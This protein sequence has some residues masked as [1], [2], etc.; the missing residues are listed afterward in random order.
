MIQDLSTD[1][2]KFLLTYT[3]IDQLIVLAQSELKRIN[4]LLEAELAKQSWFSSTEFQTNISWK[5]VQVWKKQWQPNITQNCPWIHFEYTLSWPN[6]WVQASLDIES[7]RIA[8][9]EAIQSVVGQLSRLLLE[10]KP[11]LLK[12]QGWMIRPTLEENRMILVKR[13]K[14][15][16]KFSAE[17]IFNTGKGLFDQL[18]EVIP[19]V[20]RTVNELFVE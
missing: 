8:S 10:E 1:V 11:K 7:Q 3:S 12:G 4:G 19:Y 14:I 5:W 16:D 6:Q 18:S 20:D 13:C 2:K 17:W 9:R 15:D